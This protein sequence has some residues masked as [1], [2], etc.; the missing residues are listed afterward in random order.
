MV[1]AGLHC[2]GSMY[3]WASEGR[4]CEVL[5]KCGRPGHIVEQNTWLMNME[6]EVSQNISKKICQCPAIVG[7]FTI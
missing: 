4:L 6:G 7:T 5:I 2:S 3:L 1:A